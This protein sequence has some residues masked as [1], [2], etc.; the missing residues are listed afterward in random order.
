MKTRLILVLAISAATLTLL[1]ADLTMSAVGTGG[2]SLRLLP[3][4]SAATAFLEGVAIVIGYVAI[5][6]I[7][8]RKISLRASG[9]LLSAALL[10][11]IGCGL[12]YDQLG[13]Q[14][15]EEATDLTRRFVEDPKQY[16]SRFD[17][18]ETK[19]MF[20]A[21]SSKTWQL[22]PIYWSN[23]YGR[24]VYELGSDDKR[25]TI[26]L[27]MD[28]SGRLFFVSDAGSGPQGDSVR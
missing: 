22:R 14:S 3:A 5:V 1:S 2:L 9:A 10:T 7:A 19:Q 16:E 13:A 26:Q 24:Y 11:G 15:R 18:N 25:V 17:S 27:N 6:W 21:I 12:F 23:A 4:P 8:Y 28:R 20:Y